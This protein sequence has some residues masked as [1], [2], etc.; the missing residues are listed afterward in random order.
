MIGSIQKFTLSV[1]ALVIFFTG[2]TFAQNDATKGDASSGSDI[3]YPLPDESIVDRVPMISVKLPISDPQLDVT[4]I[5]IYV[6]GKEVTAEAQISLDYIFYEPQVPMALGRHGAVIVAKDSA[7]KDMTP[8]QW[9]FNIVSQPV[10]RQAP[11][12]KTAGK[13]T[14][15]GRYVIKFKDIY[16]NEATRSQK[17]AAVPGSISPRDIK[18]EEVPHVTGSYDFTFQSGVKSIIGKIERDITP[19]SGRAR[20]DDGFSFRIVNSEKE[21]DTTFGDSLIRNTELSINGAPLRGIYRTKKIRKYSLT[22]FIGRTREPHDGRLKRNSYGMIIRTK[23]SKSHAITLTGVHSKEDSQLSTVTAAANSDTLY[24]VRSVYSLSKHLSLDSELGTSR[25]AKSGGTLTNDHG[26]DTAMRSILRYGHQPW[27]ISVG[28][29]NIG[30]KYSPTVYSTYIETNRKG[31]YGDFSFTN[32]SRKFSLSSKY[33]VYHDNLHK[34][35][36]ATEQTRSGISSVTLNYGWILPSVTASFNKQYSAKKWPTALPA[37]SARE[38]TVFLLRT[39]KNFHDFSAFN[40][41]SIRN[42]YVRSDADSFS[43]SSNI[44]SRTLQNK[45]TVST[46]YKAFAVLSYNTGLTKG[47]NYNYNIPSNNI[48][49]ITIVST[50]NQTDG[51]SVQ[52]QIVPFKF[53]STISSLKTMKRTTN[54]LGNNAIM[55]NQIDYDQKI[56]FLYILNKKKRVSLEI[57][58]FEQEFR[59]LGNLGKSYDEQSVEATYLV[60]F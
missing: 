20:A 51:F 55:A 40:G 28:T 24:T 41:N 37:Y 30:P 3:L 46:K 15:R 1:F 36:L 4:T 49:Q 18:F 43:F 60:D 58:N 11:T 13:D 19:I 35:L 21:E 5:K 17:S 34:T 29:R 31:T 54:V 2:T 25:H 50:R 7:G 48:P 47:Y 10:V 23:A 16:L 6:D 12:A 42:D 22:S 27:S 33:D 14:F 57:A 53:I 8:I 9:K 38:T 45:W 32:P 44:I 39:T 56:T 52:M 59:A 26:T